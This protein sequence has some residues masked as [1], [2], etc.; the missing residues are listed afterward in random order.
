MTNRL[1]PAVAALLAIAAASAVATGCGGSSEHDGAGN[2]S[3][4]ITRARA[5]AY[6]RAVNMKASDLPEMT[7]TS[8]ERE[9]ASASKEGLEMRSCAANLAPKLRVLKVGS[10]KFAGVLGSEHQEI[11]SNVEVMPTAALAARDNTVDKSQRTLTCAEHVLPRI[12]GKQNGPRVHYGP[13]SI[14]RLSNPLPGVAGSY[15]IRITVP[16]LGVP[17]ATE[18]TEPHLYVDGFSFLAG[19][20]EVS[21]IATAFPQPVSEEAENRLLSVLD[22]RASANKL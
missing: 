12:F 13:I 10:A 21:M 9:I 18:P 3:R 5:L 20:A 22:T 6:A 8:H 7:A 11:W 4:P 2:A 1:G 16:I 19:P 15:G 14:T 17:T